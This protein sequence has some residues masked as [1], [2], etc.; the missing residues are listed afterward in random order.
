M[1]LMCQFEN[2]WV[3]PRATKWPHKIS[4]PLVVVGQQGK[5]R[6]LDKKRLACE[7]GA[8]FWLSQCSGSSFGGAFQ[9]CVSF[10]SHKA[11]HHKTVIEGS[12]EKDVLNIFA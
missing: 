5:N 7:Q 6:A 4:F 10:S 9:N 1:D 3:S 12:L 2:G 11:W 8:D